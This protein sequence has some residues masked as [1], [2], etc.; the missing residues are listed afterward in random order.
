MEAVVCGSSGIKPDPSL[1]TGRGE[2]KVYKIETGVPGSTRDGDETGARTRRRE[3]CTI[4][5]PKD[6]KL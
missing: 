4:I 3:D 2:E 6:K 5:R 1:E